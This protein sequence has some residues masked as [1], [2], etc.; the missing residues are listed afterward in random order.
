MNPEQLLN[1]D[2]IY[3]TLPMHIFSSESSWCPWLQEQ[4]GVP[5]ACSWWWEQPPLFFSQL[6]TISNSIPFR[7][8]Q[9]RIISITTEKPEYMSI[10]FSLLRGWQTLLEIHQHSIHIKV[11]V[12]GLLSIVNA[13]TILYTNKHINNVE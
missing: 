2:G 12:W 4:R 8:E 5:I 7:K 13:Y 10:M 1:E 9:N 11:K 6:L 3:Q